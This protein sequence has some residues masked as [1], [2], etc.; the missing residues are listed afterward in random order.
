MKD[1]CH[2]IATTKVRGDFFSVEVL[3]GSPSD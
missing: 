3:V 2:H 1:L